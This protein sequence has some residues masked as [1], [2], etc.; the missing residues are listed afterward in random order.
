MV[1]A[2]GR[3][4][5]KIWNS[6]KERFIQLMLRAIRTSEEASRATGLASG[7]AST[8]A[9]AGIFL[10]VFALILLIRVFM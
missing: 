2:L 4:M 5:M 3:P 10:A 9:A 8:G 7:M 1:M 6:V